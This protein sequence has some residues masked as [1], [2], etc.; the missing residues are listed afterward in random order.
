MSF[1]QCGYQIDRN[2]VSKDALFLIETNIK[3]LRDSIESDGN[4][5]GD[6]QVEKS[7]SWYGAYISDSLL[8]LMKDRIE[9]IT[10]K[11]LNP[12]Y[13]CLRVY[14][15]GA[16]LKPH[17]DRDSCEYSATFSVTSDEPSWPIWFEGK[18]LSLNAGDMCV[19]RGT[20]LTH[21]REKYEGEEHIQVFLHYVDA[22]GKHSEN[23]MDGRTQFGG[24]K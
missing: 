1:D 10:G 19:Y 18:P 9:K 6:P 16:D 3:M 4:P 23:H 8:L 12:S 20:E 17:K 5:H 24:V 22:N 15:N 7:F 14:Y 11:T 21:W 13:S 2:V